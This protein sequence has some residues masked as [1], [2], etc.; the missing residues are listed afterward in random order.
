MAKRISPAVPSL[1]PATGVE[2]QATRQILQRLSDAHQARNSG[3]DEGFVTRGELEKIAPVIVDAG[4]KQLLGGGAP[5]APSGP[6]TGGGGGGGELPGGGVGDMIDAITRDIENS[7][8]WKKLGE[9]I[10]SITGQNSRA[11]SLLRRLQDGVTREISEQRSETRASIYTLNA[12]KVSVDQ[13]VAMIAQEQTV[14]A[15]EDEAL[16]QQITTLIASV[17]TN[18]AAIESEQTVRANADSALAQDITTLQASVGSNSAAISSE[19][20]ARVSADNQ[21]RAVHAIKIDVNGHVSGYGLISELINGQVTSSFIVRANVFAIGAPEIAGAPAYIPFSVLTTTDAN[22][23][24]PG[25]YMDQAFIKNADIDTLKIAGQAV[26]VPDSVRTAGSTSI[27][28][29]SSWTTVQ[30]LPMDPE[31]GSVTVIGAATISH[32]SSTGESADHELR[33]L[34]PAGAILDDARATA[35]AGHSS[36]LV[37]IGTSEESGT[38]SLQARTQGGDIQSPIAE[39]RSLV[40]IGSK[41]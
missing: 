11:M 12:V 4:L 25:V 34:S 13:S 22:G 31:G 18:T 26:T 39:K 19:S 21:I 20:S 2:D 23:N 27:S 35:D 15:S 8:L 33:F 1:P 30:T 41:R 24:P 3:S 29:G 6:G 37:C 10:E 38:Y 36:R 9:R 14:R 28:N 32:E 40:L 17:N 7:T 16:A 5:G